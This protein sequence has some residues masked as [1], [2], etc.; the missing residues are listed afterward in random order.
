MAYTTI[1]NPELYFQIKTYSGAGGSQAQTLDGSEDMAPNMVWIK[2][3]DQAENH[4]IYDTVRGATELLV[5]HFTAAETTLSTGLTAFGSDGFTVAGSGTT[6]YSGQIYVAWCW[7]ESATSGFDIIEF[8]GNATARNISHN[9]SAIPEV[10][11]IKNHSS[12][13]S[14][15]TSYHKPVGNTGELYLNT[16]DAAGGSV[17]AWNSTTPDSSNFRLGANTG[18]NGD[19]NTIIAY[20]W[21]PIQG[22]SKFGSYTGNG[23]ADGAF[24]YTGFRPAFILMKRTDAAANWTMWDSK[25]EGYNSTND[26][27]YANTTAAEGSG[28]VYINLL[29]N[30]FKWLQTD[31]MVNASGGNYIYMAFAEAPF[32]NSEGVPC[33]AR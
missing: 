26:E 16:T 4:G 24:V 25:R 22:F 14:Y 7:K 29:S 13:S 21:A 18:V 9:L 11:I 3:R 1:D 30:G 15:W 27:I 8:T 28:N 5:P 33:N 31:G 19:G 23:D 6:G 10:I 17:A 2:C 32:V 12:S 20:V